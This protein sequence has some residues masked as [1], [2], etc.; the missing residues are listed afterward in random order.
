MSYPSPCLSRLEQHRCPVAMWVPAELRVSTPWSCVVVCCV[1]CTSKQKLF[2]NTPRMD[3]QSF[4]DK[5]SGVPPTFHCYIQSLI[6][7]PPNTTPGTAAT[8]Y[9][10]QTCQSSPSVVHNHHTNVAMPSPVMSQG[11]LFYTS[12][13]PGTGKRKL[14]TCTGPKAYQRWVWSLRDRYASETHSQCHKR[15]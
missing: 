13:S 3:T 12:P 6:I 4:R 10:P 5:S 1:R 14:V 9:V 15:R 8:Q 7:S 2:Q 11:C